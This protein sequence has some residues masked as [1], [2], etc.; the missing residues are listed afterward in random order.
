MRRFLFQL[1]GC[2]ALVIAVIQLG[3]GAAPDH[4]VAVAAVAGGCTY[5]ILLVG[6]VV[7]LRVMGFQ[8]RHASSSDGASS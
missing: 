1:S 4:A 5:S 8:T 3:C 7:V 2:V 6:A